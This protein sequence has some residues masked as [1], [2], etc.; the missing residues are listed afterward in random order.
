MYVV[1]EQIFM[2]SRGFP[3]DLVVK[4]TPANVGLGFD[5]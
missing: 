3:D 1:Y 5:P 2:E 4:N